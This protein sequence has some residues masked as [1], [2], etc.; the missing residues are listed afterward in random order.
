MIIDKDMRISFVILNPVDSANK[1]GKENF[2]RTFKTNV[3]AGFSES[4]GSQ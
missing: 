2:E 4:I 3:S 1:G